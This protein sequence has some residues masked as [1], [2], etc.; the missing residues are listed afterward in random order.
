MAQGD[1]K[2][3]TP[4]TCS[5]FVMTHNEIR[6]IP[7]DK[8]VTYARHVVDLKTQKYDPNR[9]KIAASGNLIKYPGEL[10]THTADMT[11][12]KILWKSILSTKGA[13]FMGLDIKNFYICTPLDRF[14]YTK[15]PITIIPAHI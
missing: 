7:Q 8:V 13:R 4:G 10:T 1:D 15:I 5:I 2:T 12:A 9:V 6:H 11:T 3:K 14:N